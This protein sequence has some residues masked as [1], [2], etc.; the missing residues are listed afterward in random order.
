MGEKKARNYL[1]I[2]FGKSKKVSTFALPKQTKENAK[3]Y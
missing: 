2:K 1:K 3:N